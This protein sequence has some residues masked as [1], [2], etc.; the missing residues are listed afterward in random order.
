MTSGVGF[1][2]ILLI[3]A[4]IVIFINPKQL[5]G[6]IRR[7]SKTAAQLQAAVRKYIDDVKY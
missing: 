6:L 7:V 4:L 5:P 3:L 2:E 1:S